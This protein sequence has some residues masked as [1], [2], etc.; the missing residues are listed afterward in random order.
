MIICC[1]TGFRFYQKRKFEQSLLDNWWQINRDDVKKR[2]E[3]KASTATL[4]AG[5]RP[6]VKAKSAL[7]SASSQGSNEEAVFYTVGR[8]QGKMVHIREIHCPI[9]ITRDFLVHMKRATRSGTRKSQPTGRTMYGD[10]PRNHLHDVLR[11]AK[12]GR[13]PPERLD[14]F[15]L[16]V[17]IFSRVRLD[18]WNGLSACFLFAVLRLPD[19][20][21]LR[22]RRAFRLKDHRLPLPDASTTTLRPSRSA[23]RF[24]LQL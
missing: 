23:S 15:G 14:I 8:Y 12:L 9:E 24:A 6:S 21:Q 16:V 19:F 2:H 7:F 18:Q 22:D 3:A 20:F 5:S 11:K 10:Q 4:Q 1:I 17:Q 13:S